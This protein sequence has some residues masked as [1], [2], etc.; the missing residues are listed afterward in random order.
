MRII[1]I[2]IK[3][4]PVPLQ[5]KAYSSMYTE[6]LKKQLKLLLQSVV[7]SYISI[8]RK[9]AFR[10]LESPN[11]TPIHTGVKCSVCVI[12]QAAVPETGIKQMRTTN[13]TFH[14]L[15]RLL[16]KEIKSKT[17][18]NHKKEEEKNGAS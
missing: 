8:T 16:G 5:S 12:I 4:Y 2:L 11:L 10:F 9:K 18:V 1:L 15:K 13:P 17:R 3:V 14:D 6:L 7:N